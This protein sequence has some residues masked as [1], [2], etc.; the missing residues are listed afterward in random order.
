MSRYLVVAAFCALWADGEAVC[1]H[2]TRGAA[3]RV[4]LPE[5]RRARETL[6]ARLIG[7]F[8]E[9]ARLSMDRPFD[10]GLPSCPRR[11]ARRKLGV[12]P[13]ELVGKTVAFG[14]AGRLPA[15]D[16]RIVTSARRLADLEADALADP[17]LAERLGVRCAPTLV[18]FLSEADLELVEDP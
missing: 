2:R 15:A 14:P 6:A 11:A 8:G 7:S 1:V 3:R 18:R 4:S 13:R 10:S 17:V 9:A 12:V 5:V 16:F